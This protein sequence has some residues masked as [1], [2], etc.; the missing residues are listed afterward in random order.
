DRPESARVAAIFQG[1]PSVGG[2][3]AQP[4]G[5][6][7]RCLGRN[8]PDRVPAPTLLVRV[9]RAEK[10][11]PAVQECVK[12]KL[13]PK[14][15]EPP[16]FD[17]AG[18]FEDSGSRTP[19]IFILSPGVDPMAQLL[20]FA[21][22]KGFGGQKCQSISLG[23]GQ[24]PIAPAMFKEAQ[25]AGS[26]V[27]LQNCHLTVSWLPAIVNDMASVHKDFRLWL[28]SYLSDRFPASILQ[29]GVKMTNEP[30]KDIKAN[31][32][33]SFVSDP[34]A[35]EKFFGGCSKPL[36]WEKLLFGICMFHAVVQ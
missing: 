27:V 9:L 24:G 8:L 7:R 2:A 3:A 17:L 6:R 25:K 26:W 23:Q 1:P 35:D 36:E 14:F 13:G 16:T 28:T 18:S 10:T 30:P 11:V 31:L 5:R 33:K 19:L 34:V 21:D 20:K 32:L 15:I 29:H 12:A 4:L 22:D